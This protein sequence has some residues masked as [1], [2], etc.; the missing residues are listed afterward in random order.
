MCWMVER[1]FWIVS[2]FVFVIETMRMNSS[3]SRESSWREPD[4][5]REEIKKRKK[6]EWCRIIGDKAKQT[7]RIREGHIETRCARICIQREIYTNV[8]RNKRLFEI[9]DVEVDNK[10]IQ[11]FHYEMG[12]DQIF[13]IVLRRNIAIMRRDVRSKWKMCIFFNVVR[14]ISR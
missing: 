14:A 10:M 3:W 6:K 7:S 4:V 1:S 11:G 2:R 5:K 8:R 12:I 13:N 9:G